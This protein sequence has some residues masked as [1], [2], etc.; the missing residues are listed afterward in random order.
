M[1]LFIRVAL[2]CQLAIIGSGISAQSMYFH[3]NDGNIHMYPIDEINSIQFNSDNINLFMSDDAVVSYELSALNFY[4]YF[5]ESV[6]LLPE[7]EQPKLMLYPNP[8][9]TNLKLN[10]FFPKEGEGIKMQII[11]RKGTIIF[12][13]QLDTSEKTIDVDVSDLSAGHYYCT[14]GSGKFMLSKAFIKQ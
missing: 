8:V 12:E 7:I 1:R 2:I 9:E 10:Y 6:T 4:R 14:I 11:D 13:K 5:P 3:L